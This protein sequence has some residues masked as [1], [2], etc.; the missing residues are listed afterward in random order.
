MSIVPGSTI[1]AQRSGSCD[2]ASVD[3][4]NVS[5]VYCP[6][7]RERIQA[8][9]QLTFN[10]ANQE[11]VALVGPSGSGKTTTLRLIAGLEQPT[12]GTISF[13]NGLMNNERAERDVSMVFQRDALYPHLTVFENMAFGAR[14]R[15]VLNSEILERVKNA[16]KMLGLLAV[17]NRYP[18][19]LSSGQRHRVAIGRAIVRQPKVLLFD[20]P[21]AN[22]DTPMRHQLRRELAQLHN[23]LGT[24]TLY[25]TH[26]QAEAMMLG[27]RVAVL[28]DGVLQQIAEPRALYQHPANLFVAG[29]IGSPPMN[30]F[31]GRVSA[32]DGRFQFDENNPIGASKGGRFRITLEAERGQ[33]LIRFSEGNVVLGVRSEQISIRV[34]PTAPDTF[35][36]RV[37]VVEYHGFETRLH[38]NTGAHC[39]VARVGPDFHYQVGEHLSLQFDLQNAVFFNP[40]SGTPIS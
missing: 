33:R 7:K 3:L 31:W 18:S 29:F 4:K 12:E 22:I 24:T 35:Q 1:P 27:Q 39:F 28:N 15:S 30:L 38:F 23:R 16:A 34:G 9:T 26:D 8:V 25:V 10:V 20:E 19:A 37:E 40:A 11:M 5:K 2:M 14:L 13:G 6:N 17:L 36:A 32:N 21:F